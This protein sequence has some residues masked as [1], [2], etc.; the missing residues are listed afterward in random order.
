MLLELYQS[1]LT[2]SWTG[3]ELLTLK[4][5]LWLVQVQKEVKIE[6]LASCFPL[7]ILMESRRKKIQ[8]FLSLP[9]LSVVICWFPLMKLVLEK[10]YPPGSRLII[11]LDRTQWQTNNI[12]LV[13][14]CWKK[15]ALPIYWLQMKKPGK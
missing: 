11:T 15:R 12:L 2:K 10:L 6:T 5:L 4:I 9:K 3:S 13:A 1:Y 14:V 8:R 7:P